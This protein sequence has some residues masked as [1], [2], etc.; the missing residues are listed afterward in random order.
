MFNDS[1][2]VHD[3]T[4]ECTI[5]ILTDQLDHPDTC[6]FTNTTVCPGIDRREALSRISLDGKRIG[7]TLSRR[8]N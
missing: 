5:L 6:S 4:Q 2:L 1:H 8:Q 7:R 3:W